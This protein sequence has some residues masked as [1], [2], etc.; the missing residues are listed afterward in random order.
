MCT[1]CVVQRGLRGARRMTPLVVVLLI[2]ACNGTTSYMDATGAAGSREATL[3]WWLTAVA[4][5]VVAFV[6]VAVL[7]GMARHRNDPHR[8]EEEE[9]GEQRRDAAGAAV[10]G[11]CSVP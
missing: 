5:V 1:E 6:S 4:C 9:P 11:H 3:G 10:N 7:L 8:G 2:A